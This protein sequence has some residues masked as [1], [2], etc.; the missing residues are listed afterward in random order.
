MVRWAAIGFTATVSLL[1]PATWRTTAADL[2]EDG[3]L[4]KPPVQSF[5]TGGVEVKVEVDRGAVKPGDEV[6][7]KLIAFADTPQRVGLI[8][9]EQQGDS[10]P[11]ERVERAPVTLVK[12]SVTVEAAPGGGKPTELTFRLPSSRGGK[13]GG[14]KPYSLLVQPAKPVDSDENGEYAAALVSLITHEPEAYSVSI[15]PPAQVTPGQPFELSV[16][17]KNP[18][19]QAIKGLHV[20]LSPAPEIVQAQLMGDAGIVFGGTAEDWQVHPASGN[21]EDAIEIARLAPGEERVVKY[22]VQPGKPIGRFLV[23]ASAWSDNAGYA[24]DWEKI[25]SST[26]VAGK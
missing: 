23:L 4:V 13:K 3:A 18:G 2:P 16:R 26:A 25:D 17:V 19:K 6:H 10:E 8:V 15:E 7:L 20:E 12:K 9:R 14:V 24:L 5:R 21:G 1:I 22:Q 11:M